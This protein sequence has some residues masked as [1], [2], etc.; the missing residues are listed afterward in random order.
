MCDKFFKE[1]WVVL[2]IEN[3]YHQYYINTKGDIIYLD[4][5]G[6]FKYT[7]KRE[8]RDTGYLVT[9][10]RVKDE[11]KERG[12]R[13]SEMRI[14][15]LVCQTFIGGYYKRRKILHKDGDIKNNNLK[16]LKWQYGFPNGVD[17]NYLRKLKDDYLTEENKLLKKYFLSNDVKYIYEIFW[18]N[19]GLLYCIFSDYKLYDEFDNF[20]LEY[21]M[22]IKKYLDEGKIMPAI[23]HHVYNKDNVVNLIK[24]LARLR[25][26]TFF[27]EKGNVYN[28][29][30]YN[31]GISLNESD[32][33]Y[34]ELTLEEEILE[35]FSEYS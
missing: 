1:K 34:K 13:E 7:K 23:K 28:D 8:Y 11:T 33:E 5:H 10:I 30:I 22:V 20:M 18:K 6:R 35:M 26:K 2:N 29:K 4:R 31:N 17:Y 19:K 15:R 9:K 12:Y 14:D 21:P 3:P 27:K 25:I 16:N 32:F 24:L